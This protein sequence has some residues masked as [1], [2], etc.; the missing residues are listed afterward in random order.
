MTAEAKLLIQPVSAE[1]GSSTQAEGIEDRMTMAGL[2]ARCVIDMIE[3]GNRIVSI[4]TTIAAQGISLRGVER[5][6]PRMKQVYDRVR[7]VIPP[8]A[9]G[10]APPTASIEAFVCEIENGTL[11]AAM[12]I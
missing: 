6:G 12:Q 7:Q 2:S 1:I 11:Y 9:P 8:L 4:S 3:L 5:L 10:D